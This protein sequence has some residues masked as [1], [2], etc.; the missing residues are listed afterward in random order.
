M[1]AITNCIQKLRTIIDAN[2]QMIGFYNIILDKNELESI[3]PSLKF[4]KAQKKRFENAAKFELEQLIKQNP[5][6]N[7]ENEDLRLTIIDTIDSN[8]SVEI[9]LL[10]FIEVERNFNTFYLNVISRLNPEGAVYQRL[11]NH[12]DEMRMSLTMLEKNIMHQQ[13][14]MIA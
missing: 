11:V 10:K 4:L 3:D 8:K 9:Y 14:L 7:I 13:K 6:L 12:I 1:N 5:N 2:E